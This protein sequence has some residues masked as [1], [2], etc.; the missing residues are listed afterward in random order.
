MELSPPLR[1]PARKHPLAYS[2][3]LVWRAWVEFPSPAPVVYAERKLFDSENVART[4][5]AMVMLQTSARCYSN[6]CTRLCSFRDRF[7][8]GAVK[9]KV[10]G[11]VR[12]YDVIDVNL[13]WNTLATLSGVKSSTGW[14]G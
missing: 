11:C 1:N 4:I 8:S 12:A 3:E 9:Y 10:S 5:N 7:A 2:S 13:M 6:S 14:K